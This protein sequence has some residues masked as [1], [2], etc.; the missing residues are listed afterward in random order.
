MISDITGRPVTACQ[1]VET[2]CLGAAMMATAA[3]DDTSDLREV[4]ATMSGD[5]TTYEPDEKRSAFYDRIYNDVFKELYPR[6]SDLFPALAAA[7]EDQGES[8][9]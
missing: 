4:A 2:T 8:K 1:E 7:V 3:M 6:L 5:G 9:T